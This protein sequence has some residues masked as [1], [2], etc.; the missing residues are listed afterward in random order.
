[1]D[2]IYIVC[3]FCNFGGGTPELYKI[4]QLHKHNLWNIENVL[5][6]WKYN[7]LKAS[8]GILIENALIAEYIFCQNFWSGVKEFVIKWVVWYMLTFTT[9]YCFFLI[10]EYF[11]YAHFEVSVIKIWICIR[12]FNV[13]YLVLNLNNF[14]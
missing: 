12:K 3:F 13:F 5:H 1:M 2:W 7:A 11:N 8:F 6:Y 10:V 14:F 4:H 9:Y